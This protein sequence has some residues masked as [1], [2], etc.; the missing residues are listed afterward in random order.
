M[1]IECKRRSYLESIITE[2]RKLDGVSSIHKII[3]GG[4]HDFLLKINGYDRNELGDKVSVISK[5]N[6]VNMTVSL[7]I[8]SPS[9]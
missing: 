3:K 1:L 5:F 2:L 7:I 4:P 9:E 8:S 6:K